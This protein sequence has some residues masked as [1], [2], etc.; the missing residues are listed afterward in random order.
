MWGV[1]QIGSHFFSV[2]FFF[3]HRFVL[4]VNAP[5]QLWK[6]FLGTDLLGFS[7]GRNLGIRKAKS[8]PQV[9]TSIGKKMGAT[10]P[11]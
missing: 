9:R 5:L 1:V 7:I 4:G 11:N 6:P 2:F 8:L 10:L 3:D